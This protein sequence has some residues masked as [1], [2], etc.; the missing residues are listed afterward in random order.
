MDSDNQTVGG[1]IWKIVNTDARG[2]V[3]AMMNLQQQLAVMQTQETVIQQ[4]PVTTETRKELVVQQVIIV[5]K[6]NGHVEVILNTVIVCQAVRGLTW[7][8][9]LTDAMEMVHAMMT[10]LLLAA[11]Q[12]QETVIQQHH[13]LTLTQN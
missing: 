11:I 6:M 5:V 2:M 8:T 12:R 10:H 13:V 4:H 7:K 9:A 3:H 1:Q